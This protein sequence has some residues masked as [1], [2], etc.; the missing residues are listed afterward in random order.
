MDNGMK[1][2]KTV[3]MGDMQLNVQIIK[4]VK[5]EMKETQGFRFP[6]RKPVSQPARV[7][8]YSLVDQS[9]AQTTP[10]GHKKG[11][12][13]IE[14]S[15]FTTVVESNAASL[16]DALEAFWDFLNTHGQTGFYDMLED[17]IVEHWIKFADM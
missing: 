11:G 8:A 3:S 1:Y 2:Q 7:L 9:K 6:I 13:L 16:G 17:L 15:R 14:A 12:A 5:T 10:E 4:T